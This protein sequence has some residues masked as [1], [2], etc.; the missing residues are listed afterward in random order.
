MTQTSI[1]ATWS[2]S[3]TARRT[4]RSLGEVLGASQLMGDSFVGR[5]SVGRA[6]ALAGSASRA[7]ATTAP[8]DGGGAGS[9]EQRIIGLAR[10]WLVRRPA[11]GDE[12]TN[13]IGRGAMIELLHAGPNNQWLH[14]AVANSPV[15]PLPPPSRSRC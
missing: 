14:N 6:I 4:C 5:M 7:R 13:A 3:H 11:S 2:D 10:R 12:W 15:E 1:W 9:D 8:S